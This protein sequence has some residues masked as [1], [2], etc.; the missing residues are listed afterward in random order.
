MTMQIQIKTPGDQFVWDESALSRLRA[1]LK[2]GHNRRKI[3]EI[4]SQEQRRPFTK[5]QIHGAVSRYAMADLFPTNPGRP[6]ENK[7][8]RQKPSAPRLFR[9]NNVIQ[10]TKRN[11]TSVIAPPT[12]R[13]RSAALHDYAKCKWIDG[14]PMY[15][16]YS[17]CGQPAALNGQGNAKPYCPHHCSIAYVAPRARA[18]VQEEG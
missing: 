9:R 11:D 15:G 1:L 12:S 16:E 6:K 4:F 7:P 13:I 17:V 8:K 5:N 2:A 10:F 18:A 14:D 3:A